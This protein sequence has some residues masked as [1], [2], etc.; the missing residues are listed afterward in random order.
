[1]SQDYIEECFSPQ[2]SSIPEE[3]YKSCSREVKGYLYEMKLQAGL[4]K[5][6]IEFEANPS[7]FDEWKQKTATGY[8]LKIKTKNG[9]IL[10]E[11]KFTLKPIYHSWFIRDWLARS[12]TIF[13]TNNKW[14]ISYQDK[15]LLEQY[16]K[17]LLSTSEFYMYIEE[18]NN[19]N[20][21][22][23]LNVYSHSNSSSNQVYSIP[24]QSKSEVKL[25]KFLDKTPETS[26]KTDNKGRLP[27]CNNC[28]NR[29]GCTI[30]DKLDTLRRSR[31]DRRGTQISID[32]LDRLDIEPYKDR[33]RKWI[34]E[35]G[36]VCYEQDKCFNRR[37]FLHSQKGLRLF[38]I[39]D[40][41]NEQS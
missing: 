14:N 3:E 37:F 9:S 41:K 26:A 11:A 6:G 15:R 8:D 36:K 40:V 30:L 1:M 27:E 20:K 18:L 32:N 13:V 33:Y 19:D 35:Y 31:P 34:I 24:K 5:R 7:N 10:V 17:K 25:D 4:D 12:A 39:E 2:L 21:Y 22:D 28:K 16:H 29:F 23:Y 38:D